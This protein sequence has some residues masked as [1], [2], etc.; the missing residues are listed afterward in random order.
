MHISIVTQSEVGTEWRN[1]R[2]FSVHFYYAFLHR[3]LWEFFRLETCGSPKSIVGSLLCS[4]HSRH[5]TVAA[6]EPEQAKLN[7]FIGILRAWKRDGLGFVKV[8][9][10]IKPPPALVIF[11]SGAFLRFQLKEHFKCRSWL[12][13]C[14]VESRCHFAEHG[15]RA[16]CDVMNMIRLQ[17]EFLL[18]NVQGKRLYV[19]KVLSCD[20]VIRKDEWCEIF[21]S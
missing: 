1:I 4:A 5:P 9:L 16:R 7:R 8:R 20:V 21:T 19:T 13:D 10:Q 17:C 2:N 11:F 14:S 15:V 12:S 6:S 3:F 18:R